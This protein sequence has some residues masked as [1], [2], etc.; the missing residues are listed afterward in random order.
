MTLCMDSCQ[1]WMISTVGTNV[2]YWIFKR[3]LAVKMQGPV[4]RCA[5]FSQETLCAYLCRVGFAQECT[6]GL[7]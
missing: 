3:P 6:N 1:R 4:G 7:Q 2:G 5:S